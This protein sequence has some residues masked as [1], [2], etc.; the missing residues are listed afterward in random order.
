[1]ESC[2]QLYDEY[3]CAEQI[4][5]ADKEHSP[6]GQR[7]CR[8]IEKRYA[9]DHFQWRC[10]DH[11]IVKRDEKFGAILR[12]THQHE[13][14]TFGRNAGSKYDHVYPNHE[15]TV[16]RHIRC[17]LKCN[18]CIKSAK[19]RCCHGDR[20]SGYLYWCNVVTV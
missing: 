9:T 10:C 8:T 17:E 5:C 6:S 19:N 20:Y 18:D 11:Y 15:S 1:M 3:C 12:N 16:C 7:T 14:V 2:L 4:A 13:P